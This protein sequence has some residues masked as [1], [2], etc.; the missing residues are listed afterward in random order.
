AER[1]LRD[2]R[3]LLKALGVPWKG[4]EASSLEAET[5][6]ALQQLL[7]EGR[8]RLRT[9]FDNPSL[10]HIDRIQPD[11]KA[12]LNAIACSS[13][14]LQGTLRRTLAPANHRS[15]VLPPDAQDRLQWTPAQLGEIF[16]K[17]G[18]SAENNNCWF[19]SMAQLSVAE[20]VRD[21]NAVVWDM[22][23]RLRKVSDL[24]GFTERG[25]M[26]ETGNPGMQLLSAILNVQMRIFSARGATLFLQPDD[27]AGSPTAREVY[28]HLS[29]NH[30][31]P[32]W[33][34]SE[35]RSNGSA[36]YRR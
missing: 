6:Q 28:L 29:N 18:A 32:L 2:A 9:I 7:D 36:G 35:P 20:D 30:F 8:R 11:E 23:H 25:M 34:R 16:Y 15:N 22:T 27:V 1:T 31:E 3:R 17:G 5:R 21:R 33:P 4:D 26:V 19:H 13:A 14:D 24:L 10:R 12:W